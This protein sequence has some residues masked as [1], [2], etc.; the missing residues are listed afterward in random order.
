[1]WKAHN[2]RVFTDPVD[3]LRL[4]KLRQQL[5]N[6]VLRFSRDP[7]RDVDDWDREEGGRFLIACLSCCAVSVLLHKL[8]Y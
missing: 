3:K 1:M 7:G 8:G 2:A 4:K 5:Q 6:L